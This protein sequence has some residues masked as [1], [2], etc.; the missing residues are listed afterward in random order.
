M[1]QSDNSL[2]LGARTWPRLYLALLGT[3]AVAACFLPLA[4]HAGYE[5]SELIALL[6]GLFGGIPGISAART[7]RP[8]IS[9]QRAVPF[10]V[11]SLLLPLG[12]VLLNGLRR[13]ACE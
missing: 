11:F 1:A 13:P 5:F 9:L 2:P 4:D 6:A 10:G 7:S 8:R 3:A 12:I